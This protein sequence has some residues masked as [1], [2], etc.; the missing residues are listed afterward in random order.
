MDVYGPTCSVLVPSSLGIDRVISFSSWWR[1]EGRSAM[2]CVILRNDAAE[3]L[4]S[5]SQLELFADLSS[6]KLMYVLIAV[7]IT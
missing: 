4:I 7:L 2:P 6:T 1:L 3:L 5:D